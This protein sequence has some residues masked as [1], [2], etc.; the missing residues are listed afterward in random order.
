MKP[1]R[2]RLGRVLAHRERE[3]NE[4]VLGLSRSRSEAERA[5][6]EALREEQQRE[7]AE[8][9]RDGLSSGP[10]TASDW[11]LMSD[12]VS[13]RDLKHTRAR[14][15][16]L[17][18]EHAVAQAQLLVKKAHVG[19]KS[20]KALSDRLLEEENRESARREQRENDEHGLRRVKG[21]GRR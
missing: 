16:E 19:V 3:L 14:Q 5:R 6:A 20:V 15:R 10:A 21:E 11:S 1:R 8:R 9:A 4:R 17:Q 12:W 7:A 2:A 18:A 13:S